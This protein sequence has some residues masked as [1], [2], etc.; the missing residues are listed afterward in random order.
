MSKSEASGHAF[1]SWEGQWEGYGSIIRWYASTHLSLTI[2]SKTTFKF[3]LLVKTTTRTWPLSQA[4]P[5]TFWSKMNEWVTHH[6]HDHDPISLLRVFCGRNWYHHMRLYAYMLICLVCSAQD[7]Q[8]QQSNLYKTKNMH[9][10]AIKARQHFDHVGL[11]GTVRKQ[12]IGR[13]WE[14]QI[15]TN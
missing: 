12:T 13:L 7:N 2:M 8:H 6:V 1:S 15:D 11:Q 5:L 9:D 10:T 14:G 4:Q 3:E